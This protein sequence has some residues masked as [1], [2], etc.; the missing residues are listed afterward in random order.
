MQCAISV[1]GKDEVDCELEGVKEGINDKA[2]Q[3]SQYNISK[4]EDPLN[5]SS[6]DFIH[7]WIPSYHGNFIACFHNGHGFGLWVLA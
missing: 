6:Q 5:K 1:E 4:G 7:H 2:E 3:Y